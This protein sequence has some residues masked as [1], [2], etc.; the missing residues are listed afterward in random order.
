MATGITPDNTSSLSAGAATTPA[1]LKTFFEGNDTLVAQGQHWLVRALPMH[2]T[3]R[4]GGEYNY[5]IVRAEFVARHGMLH[6]LDLMGEPAHFRVQP[7]RHS[8]FWMDVQGAGGLAAR[9]NVS[10]PEAVLAVLA[11][12]RSMPVAARTL[13]KAD[14]IFLNLSATGDWIDNATVRDFTDSDGSGASL[15]QAQ[16]LW[17]CAHNDA[18]MNEMKPVIKQ[19]PYTFRVCCL[20]QRRAR[21]PRS[22]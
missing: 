10:E 2:A 8:Q 14:V 18:E 6:G 9:D 15:A 22:L 17:G 1:A 21:R 5:S 3:E 16:D 20:L 19:M 4:T 7:A 11:A 12:A 13:K